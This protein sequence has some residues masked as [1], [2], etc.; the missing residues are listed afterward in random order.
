V[1]KTSTP[2]Q[3]APADD[4]DAPRRALAAVQVALDRRDNG[5]YAGSAGDREAARP[6]RTGG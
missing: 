4:G 1:P 2:K 6:A 5:G 3:T